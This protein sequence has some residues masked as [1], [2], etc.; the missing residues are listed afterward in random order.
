MEQLATVGTIPAFESERII[1]RPMNPDDYRM[2]FAWQS[3]LRN[4]HLWW[5]DRQILAFDDFVEDFRKRLRG[6][7]QV[8]FIIEL[9]EEEESEPVGMIYAYNTS[10]TDGYTYLCIY[11][12]PRHTALGIGPEAGLIMADY[13]FSFYNFR[14]IYAGIFAYNDPSLKAAKR[15]RFVEEGCLRSHRWFMDRYW[16]LIILALTRESFLELKGFR[17]APSE[18]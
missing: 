9:C 12:T 5:E 7:I 15:N 2:I 13:L 10:F 8:L 18:D 16:D 4:L 1:L 17:M 14:K 6:P 11:L 3:D